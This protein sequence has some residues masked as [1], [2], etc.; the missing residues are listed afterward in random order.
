M[1]LSP[2]FHVPEKLDKDYYAAL[3]VPYDATPEELR[4]A[5]R[6]L[7]KK[8]HPD[9]TTSGS[10]NAERFAAVSEAYEVLSTASRRAAYDEGRRLHGY[11][12][13]PRR[14]PCPNAAAL[15]A[16]AVQLRQHLQQIDRLRMNHEALRDYVLELLRDENL[17]C[18]DTDPA[19]RQRV[20]E[21]AFESVQSLAPRLLPDV[22]ERMALLAGTDAGLLQQWQKW[23]TAQARELKWNRYRPAIVIAF[24]ALLCVVLWWLARR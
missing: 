18:L 14:R 8:F 11:Q 13:A 21:C 24:A 16:Q 17:R 5:Y 4:A 12:R 6:H 20:F 15:L 9:A 3:G 22:A 1:L 2:F 10:L 23:E 7:A 19:A